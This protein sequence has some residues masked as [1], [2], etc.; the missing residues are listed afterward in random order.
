LNERPPRRPLREIR[1]RRIVN[2]MRSATRRHAA[3][4]LAG[5]VAFFAFLSILPALAA[6]VSIYGLVANPDDVARQVEA[7]AGALPSDV[8]R[9]IHDQVSALTGRSPGTLS[10]EA[11]IGIIAAIWAATK[12]MKALITGLSLAFGQ[13][14]TRGFIRLG[15]TA[16]LFTVGA[17]ISGVISI[18]SVIVLPIVLSFFRMSTLG[19]QLIR[20]G[21]W[22]MLTVMV[23]V[24]LSVAYH[25]G[26]AHVPATRRW[27]SPGSVTATVLWLAGSGLF[28]WLA[29]TYAKTDRVD[30][31]LG[32]IITILTWFLLSAYIVILG[33]ELDAEIAREVA[34]RRDQR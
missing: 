15:V 18:A 20:W 13:K 1:W 8:Q 30:G 7:V 12:G 22:P 19:E 25:Y 3:S 26:P 28:S 27:L 9:A 4:V 29:S 16:F 17:I 31:S 34:A 24:G 2:Q 33:A 5:G 11:A 10:I 21:R 23:L 32:V 6:L 14:E